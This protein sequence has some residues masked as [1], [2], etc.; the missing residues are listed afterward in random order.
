[1]SDPIVHSPSGLYRPRPLLSGHRGIVGPTGDIW[2]EDADN[3]LSGM[4]VASTGVKVDPLLDSL[5]VMYRMAE[6]GDQ[7]DY[8]YLNR[9][10]TAR[11]SPTKVTGKVGDAQQ[12]AYA[13]D[14]C[15][16]NI[17]GLG[18]NNNSFSLNMWVRSNSAPSSVANYFFC[19]ENASGQTFRITHSVVTNKFVVMLSPDYGSSG[20]TLSS[21]NTV[22]IGTWYNVSLAYVQDTGLYFYLNNVWQNQGFAEDGRP[23]HRMVFGAQNYGGLHSRLVS[24]D[25]F[26]WFESYVLDSAE[27]TYMYNGGAGRE[28]L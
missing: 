14:C 11:N 18:A 7:T 20:V 10:L 25:A 22:S 19:L 5:L 27:R 3:S 16:Y 12:Y 28:L 17:S 1:M 21:I 23:A 24:V 26:H 13:T 8:G 2:D 4:T 15:H 9:P 6:T